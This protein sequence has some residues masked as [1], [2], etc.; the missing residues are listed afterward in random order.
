MAL[1][2]VTLKVWTF[3]RHLLKRSQRQLARKKILIAGLMLTSMVDM[4][5][6]LVIFLLQ[7]FS[8][9]PDLMMVTKGVQLP[10]AQTGAE[11]QDAPVL[12]LSEEGVFLDQKP[13]GKLSVILENPTPLLTK[14]E[15]LRELWQ[16][17]HPQEAFKGEITLQAHK[18]LPSTLVSQF[19]GILPSQNYS[20]VQLAVIGGSP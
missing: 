18:D 19:M 9:S 16:K 5:S 1:G 3:K 4:F 10:V 6:L 15:A 20:T 12:S 7:T 8:A 17:S 11:F 2:S 14:L 13:L